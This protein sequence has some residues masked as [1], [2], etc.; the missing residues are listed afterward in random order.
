MTDS[1][2]SWNSL[3]PRC[4]D[5]RAAEAFVEWQD[6]AWRVVK[7]GA[8]AR[9]ENG[10]QFL[11]GSLMFVR[12]VEV[13]GGWGRWRAFELVERA[14]AQA[15]FGLQLHLDNDLGQR[16]LAIMTDQ[17]LANLVIHQ[18]TGCGFAAYAWGHESRMVVAAAKQRGWRVQLLAG[19]H[20]SQSG[21]IN[22]RLNETFDTAAAVEAGAPRFNLD[23]AEARPVLDALETL[24]RVTSFA[25]EAEA[26]MIATFGDVVEALSGVPAAQAIT[27]RR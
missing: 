21:V 20:V 7:R 11:G 2:V 26:W 10:P 6:G 9:A 12:A 3:Y 24:V 22:Y 15:G 14:S 5:G 1:W 4:V 27:A 19:E 13:M 18:R 17:A 25:Q 16:N 23:A 8:D